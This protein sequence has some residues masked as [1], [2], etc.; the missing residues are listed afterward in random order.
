LRIGTVGKFRDCAKR[1]LRWC[2]NQLNPC[3]SFHQVVRQLRDEGGAALKPTCGAPLA[4]ASEAPDPSDGRCL[5]SPEFDMRATT[6][7][8][9]GG[10]AALALV[11]IATFAHAQSPGDW[12]GSGGHPS[13]QSSAERSD[14]G[15]DGAV[16]MARDEDSALGSAGTLPAPGIEVARSRANCGTGSGIDGR[17]IGS[18]DESSFTF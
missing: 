1:L 10:L 17:V 13:G 2:A 8:T 3:L 14:S 15:S 12:S 16:R 9:H 18:L 5:I 7:L 6:S 11:G 4:G